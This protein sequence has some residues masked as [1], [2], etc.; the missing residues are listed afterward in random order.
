MATLSPEILRRYDRPGP[1]YTSYPTAAEFHDGVDRSTYRD[2]LTRASQRSDEPLSLYLH[3]P[4][5]EHRCLYC[6]C[7][8]VVTRK[9]EVASQYLSHLESEI[10][11]VASRLGDRRRL[12]QMHWGGGTPTYQTSDE[13]RHLYGVVRDVF[14]FEPDAEVAIEVDPRVTRDEQ[15]ET[16]RELGFNRLSLGVQDVNP[17]VQTAIDRVQ[18]F[19]LT[20][21]QVELA[22]S[23]GFSGVNID[24][25]YGLPLQT[26]DGFA[27]T[28]Q[29]V[30]ELRPD[31][32]AVYSYAHMPW[33][34]V[35]QRRI[36][37]STLPSPDL[38]LRLISDAV[39]TLTGAGYLAIGMDHFAL[40]DDELGR[41]VADGTLWR[42]FMGYTVRHAPDMVGCGTSAIGEVDGAFFQ[43]EKKLI[44]YQTAIRDHGCAIHR[45]YVLSDD[46]HVRRHVITSL[47]CHST[48]SIP[49]VE[50][51]FNIEFG[52][53]FDA[54]LQALEPLAED[55]LVELAP[56]HIHVVGVGR[57]LVRNA[58]MV[59][60]NHRRGAVSSHPRFSRTV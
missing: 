33:L 17:D 15:L 59:F 9:R 6:G 8:V 32:L 55:G 34:A 41:A 10:R 43:N 30:A 53:Y 58:A 56:S 48:L 57:L 2:H 36:D 20:V 25:I 54:E 29:Q 31:R 47:M 14:D 22:R 39:S 23:L 26:A 49:E 44:R 50:A 45:G 24:L 4:F 38:K 3:L 13:L 51:R 37:E 19:E 5:C 21:H 42:N 40:P 11:L 12:R 27:R 35:Q 46:D 7:N 52:S 18:P 28:L 60:D 1:R 16:L